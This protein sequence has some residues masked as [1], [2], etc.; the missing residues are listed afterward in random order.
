MLW[1]IFVSSTIFPFRVNTSPSSELQAQFVKTQNGLHYATF[2]APEGKIQ[3]TLT[4]DI[5]RSDSV[6]GTIAEFPKGG[7]DIERQ[8]NL[9]SLKRYVVEVE[10]ARAFISGKLIKLAVPESPKNNALSFTLRSPEGKT[11]AA[12]EIPVSPE[13][14]V[15][16]PTDFSL[17]SIGQAGRP[18][19]IRGSFDGDLSNTTASVGNQPAEIL[20]ESPRKSV[21]KSPENIVGPTEVAMK[22]GNDERRADFR[23]V[24]V[25][26]S[27]PKTNLLKGESTT[28]TMKVEGLQG[29]RKPVSIQVITTG[30][31]NMGGG[32]TQILPI[33]PEKVLPGG[34]FIATR[35]LTA[36]AAG[37]FS[38]VANVLPTPESVA[39]CPLTGEIVRIE[40]KPDG[41]N[42]LWKFRIKKRDGEVQVVYVLSQKKPELK[43]GINILIKKC[44]IDDTGDTYLQEFA[45]T[46]KPK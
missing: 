26:L 9:A 44:S 21:F 23:N 14:A 11:I 4:D 43:S 6:S 45:Q 30:T 27:A 19:T 46:G 8:N 33:Q 5:R 13:S 29:I 28:V 25:G 12:L 41:G 24:A 15:A 1:I 32:N 37:G 10:T 34:E 35:T 7:T 18:A 42:G 40:T 31:V 2:E 38:V 39:D 22:E 3:M 16:A 36:S 17:P 20:A